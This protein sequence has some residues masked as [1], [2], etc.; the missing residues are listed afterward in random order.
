[1]NFLGGAFRIGQLFGINIHV[2]FLFLIWIAFRLIS[3]GDDFRNEALFLGMLFGIVLLHEFGHCFGARWVGG[4]AR[5]IMMWPLGG[6]AYAQAPMRPG[7]QFVTVAA[8]PMVN[9]V[10]CLV[11]AAAIFAGTGGGLLP[12][13]NPLGG[14]FYQVGPITAYP[15]WLSFAYTFYRVNLFLLAFNLLPIYPLDG[16]QLFHAVVW[17][18][19][20]LQRA[21]VLACQVGLVGAAVMLILALRGGGGGIL[22]FIA[23]FGGLTCW[24]RYQAARQGL[25]VEDPIFTPTYD[26]RTPRR[27]FWSRLFGGT[28]RRKSPANDYGPPE[29]VNPNPGAWEARQAERTAEELE[30]D[31]ILKKVS[32]HGIGSLSYVE[33]QRLETITRKRQQEERQYERGRRV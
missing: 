31:R 28:A 21:T 10:L 18:F 26:P 13:I 24:Q 27:G 17:K 11:S 25:L 19:I 7:P 6:L 4:D 23:I 5:D 30:L 16:G 12:G 15:S 1:M 33:R 20:G 3:A 14:G 9:V 2:H 32:Q 22:F 8:G 29:P